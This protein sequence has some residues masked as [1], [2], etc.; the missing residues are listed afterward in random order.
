E[1]EDFARRRHR[2]SVGQTLERTARARGRALGRVLERRQVAVVAAQTFAQIAGYGLVDSLQIDH[3]I[4]LDHTEMQ[5][6]IGFETD[7]FHGSLLAWSRRPF[8]NRR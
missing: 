2:Q 6:A 1:A 4:A 5:R 3:L 7:D 8:S